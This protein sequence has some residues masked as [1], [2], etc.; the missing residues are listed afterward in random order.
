MNDKLLKCFKSEEVKA[1]LFHMFPA[2]F[3]QTH[4]EICGEEVTSAV[5]R[6]LEGRD[7][8]SNI[9]QTFVV[10]IPKVASPKGLG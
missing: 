5:L 6:V 1:A 9:N 3:F 7:D 2:H 10:L 8:M 4:W